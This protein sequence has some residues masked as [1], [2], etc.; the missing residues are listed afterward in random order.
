MANVLIQDTRRSELVLDFSAVDSHD[1]T[2]V[3]RDGSLKY[4][5]RRLLGTWSPVLRSRFGEEGGMVVFLPDFLKSTMAGVLEVVS[6]KWEGEMGITVDEKSLLFSL[7]ISTGILDDIKQSCPEDQDGSEK[8][9][10]V[11]K[12]EPKDC[13]QNQQNCAT[14]DVYMCDLCDENVSKSDLRR[15]IES[16]HEN[17]L[18]SSSEAEIR[19]FFR[20]CS[21]VNLSVPMAGRVLTPPKVIKSVLNLGELKVEGMTGVA[22]RRLASVRKPSLPIKSESVLNKSSLPIKSAS[23]PNKSISIVPRE[24]Q[25]IKAEPLSVE[26]NLIERPAPTLNLFKKPPINAGV[27]VIKKEANQAAIILPTKTSLPPKIPVSKEARECFA[28]IAKILPKSALASCPTSPEDLKLNCQ[29]CGST[30]SGTASKIKFEL[31]SHIGLSHY[32]KQLLN[33]VKNMFVD[34]KCVDCDKEFK[35]SDQQQI[36]LLYNHT[37]WVELILGETEKMLKKLATKKIGQPTKKSKLL[38]PGK[39]INLIPTSKLLLPEAKREIKEET[40]IYDSGREKVVKEDLPTTTKNESEQQSKNIKCENIDS[41]NHDN[42]LVVPSKSTEKET[43][44][45]IQKVEATS[46]VL[47]KVD[48]LL[49]HYKE[50]SPPKKAPDDIAEI[51]R[52]LL[53]IVGSPKEIDEDPDFEE[54]LDD[55]EMLEEDIELDVDEDGVSSIK[56]ENGSK[57]SGKNIRD[58]K[59]V[60]A[61]LIKM[62]E[63]S[64]DEEEEEGADEEEEEDRLQDFE[65][66]DNL[67]DV[68]NFEE[69]EEDVGLDEVFEDISDTDNCTENEDENDIDREINLMGEDDVVDISELDELVS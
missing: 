1:V 20:P 59:K 37:K 22:I 55:E 43:L 51:E 40:A 60:Q 32:K 36:H 57:D 9:L 14:T 44:M 10:I 52:R 58:I 65:D 11:A 48:A 62:Q 2:L 50:I 16:E 38:L 33:E 27:T 42:S 66:E 15:H 49:Q 30:F 29:K 63:I 35:R 4:G 54:I 8:D 67:E 61:E 17:D 26:G 12:P 21:N 68:L 19:S 7:G 53:A 41:F 34:F 6:M 3:C 13:S 25:H 64:D 46:K 5:S 47:S 23:I 24:T 69:G 56:V 28:K 18:G 31:R 45:D 39:S